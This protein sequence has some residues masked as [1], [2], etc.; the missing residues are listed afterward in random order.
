[1]SATYPIGANRGSRAA[2]FFATPVRSRRTSDPTIATHGALLAPKVQHRAAITDEKQLGALMC[3]VDEYDG[4]PTLRAALQ[5]LALTMTRPGDV[6]LMRREEIDF[7]RARWR[8]PAER[9]KMRRPHDVP[10]SKHAIDILEDI[11]SLSGG[12]ELVLPSIRSAT[13]PLS[14][15]A[16]NSA[17]RRMGYA[18][19]E[20]T[21]HG[22]RSAASTI[23]NER[24]FNPDVIEA[25][26]AHQDENDVR[27]AYNRATY[28]PERVKLMQEWA[29]LIDGFK[30]L[31][32]GG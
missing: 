25:A 2:S 5:L 16:M 23:L 4:W 12:R 18:H 14:E 10:L 28:W 31:S 24:G 8:I 9:M 26:L 17:L 21:A 6:R 20:M 19:D 15:N 22:F 3:A 30:K 11:W 27:R 29:N 13:K 1:M 32:I 7:Q